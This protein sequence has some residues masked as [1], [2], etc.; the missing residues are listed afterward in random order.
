MRFYK[1]NEG[2]AQRDDGI[3]VQIKHADYLEYSEGDLAV[4]VSIG[5]D[6]STRQIFVYASELT[7]WSRP[8][9]T[10]PISDVKKREIA[11]NLEE[12]LSLLKGA[13]VVS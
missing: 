1:L 12:A 4:D 11:R 10:V 9:P 8:A 6:P 7:H 13:F 5:Y 2:G 3:V